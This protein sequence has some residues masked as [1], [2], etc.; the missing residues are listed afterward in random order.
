MNTKNEIQKTKYKKLFGIFHTPYTL[1]PIPLLILFSFVLTG[2]LAPVSMS[3]TSKINVSTARAI[4]N[5]PEG[6]VRVENR[7]GFGECVKT[8]DVKKIEEVKKRTGGAVVGSQSQNNT[9]DNIFTCNLGP[10][11]NGSAQECM[12]S[13]VYYLI[14]VPATY[15][16]ALAGQL[17]DITMAFT[18]S[19]KVLDSDFARDGWVVTR[20]LAN[21]FFIFILLYIAITTILDIAGY[22][23]KALLARLVIV[24]L[25]LNFSLFATRVVIDASNILALAFYNSISVSSKSIDTKNSEKLEGLFGIAPKEIS[26]GFVDFF[27][28]TKLLGITNTNAQEI[29]KFVQNNLG[30]LI[31]VYLFSA[32]IILVAAWVFLSIAFLFITR[33][34]ILWFLMATAPIA[35]AAIILPKTRDIFTKWW[36]ELTSKSF[37]VAVLLFF[38]WLI[39]KFAE[40]SFLK[41]LGAGSL[42]NSSIESANNGFLITVLI[43]LLQFSTLIILLLV[44]KQQTQKMCGAV[45]GFSMNIL[46]SGLGKAA[47]F[48]AGGVGGAA[49]RNT[50]GQYAYKKAEE[51]NKAGAGGSF[52]GRLALQA[53]RKI[54]GSSL[55]VRATTLGKK[56]GLGEASGKKGYAGWVKERTAKDVALA[57][58]FGKGKV[59]DEARTQFAEN[60]QNMGIFS[61]MVTGRGVLS[62]TQQKKASKEV[63]SLVK[64]ADKVTREEEKLDELTEK[65]VG[66]SKDTPIKIKDKNGI[67]REFGSVI[68]KDGLREAIRKG[69]VGE[70]ETADVIDKMVKSRSDELTNKLDEAKARVAKANRQRTPDELAR[71]GRKIAREVEG[72]A[73]DLAETERMIEW[74]KEIKRLDERKRDRERQISDRT[75]RESQKPADGGGKDKK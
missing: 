58:S 65:L 70:Q 46:S 64:G 57:K 63:D 25:L 12:G 59:A 26:V 48:L 17:F 2:I 16:I 55:D 49:L 27:K 61:R 74:S 73:R 42:T 5:C 53:A 60:L 51:W 31:F 24:A 33:T 22:N 9:S 11:G 35:F 19:S 34:A 3:L 44:A 28:P 13:L 29:G 62:K 36:G 10:S 14:F 71:D 50:L 15:I 45:A 32:T 41:N 8:S 54:G 18:L 68:G 7:G 6:T 56:V 38:I 20:D 39:T 21:M 30:K 4:D 52:G 72:A 67:D 43:M 66:I 47:G 23:A 1:S 40:T 75:E 69:E 37:C